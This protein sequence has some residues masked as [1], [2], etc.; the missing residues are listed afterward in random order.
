VSFAT[1]T[2]CVAFQQ[3][4]VVIVVYFVNGSVRKLLNIT[5]YMTLL[6]RFGISVKDKK[7]E[8]FLLDLSLLILT[9]CRRMSEVM[10]DIKVMTAFFQNYTIDVT[11]EVH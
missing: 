5:S 10:L 8:V 4:F 3:V 1:I 6:Y 7:Q 9:S 11:D 2:L